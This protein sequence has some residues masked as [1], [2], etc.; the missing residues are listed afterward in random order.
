ME[1]WVR[2]QARMAIRVGLEQESEPVLQAARVQPAAD[3]FRSAYGF[4]V[5]YAGA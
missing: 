2:E 5:V 4:A 3:L 1:V